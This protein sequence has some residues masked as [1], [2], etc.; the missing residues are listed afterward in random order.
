VRRS[1]VKPIAT[2]KPQ[3]AVITSG[4]SRELRAF[5][6][7]LENLIKHRDEGLARGNRR[8][9]ARLSAAKDSLTKGG[10][11]T[12]E[13][14]HA[15]PWKAMTGVALLAFVLALVIAPPRGETP[16]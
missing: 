6:V 15:H 16:E 11:Q 9:N 12:N 13:Y 1:D 2:S 8:P 14:V 3:A 10:A 4:M 7:D 5:I